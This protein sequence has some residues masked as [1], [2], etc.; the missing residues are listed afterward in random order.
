MSRKDTNGLYSAIASCARKVEAEGR[1]YEGSTVLRCVK[2]F[3]PDLI[4][5]VRHTLSERALLVLCNDAAKKRTTANVSEH[6]QGQLELAGFERPIPS[7]IKFY[8]G[9][10]KPFIRTLDARESHLLS[11]KKMQE[12]NRKAC[13]DAIDDTDRML[14]LIRATGRDATLGEALDYN[15]AQNATRAVKPQ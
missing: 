13:S 11:H 1:Q 5:Q 4:E 6:V 15:E 7:S 8:D 14:L 10:N 3:H 2:R 9:S 12:D